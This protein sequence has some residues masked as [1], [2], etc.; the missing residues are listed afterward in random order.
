MKR[1]GRKRPEK[2]KGAVGK[3]GLL[4]VEKGGV[5]RERVTEWGGRKAR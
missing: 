5:R 1:R 4:S 3:G 2:E